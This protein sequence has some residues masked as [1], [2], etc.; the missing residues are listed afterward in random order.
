MNNM[1]TDPLQNAM[2][3]FHGSRFDVVTLDLPGGHRKDIVIHPG[4]VVILP[5]LDDTRVVLIRND[6]IAVGQTLWELPAGT[7]EPGEKPAV[8]AGR[9]LI[10]ETGY[11]A[12]NITPLCRF[13]SSPGICT[14]DMWIYLARDLKHVGQDL[15]ATER[16]VVEIVTFEAALTMVRTGEIRD[17]K[18]IAS[19]LYHHVFGGKAA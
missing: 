6:R 3:V 11:E 1:L 16:I 19:L 7:L 8:C 4:A 2:R 10:E 5:L 12:A 15:D 13:F 14:E 18:T 17:G 9:E